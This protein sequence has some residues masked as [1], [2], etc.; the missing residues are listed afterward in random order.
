MVCGGVR[1]TAGIIFGFLLDMYGPAV[2]NGVAGA[3]FVA[4]CIVFGYKISLVFGYG[5]I[6]LAGA[7]TPSVRYGCVER[8]T[9]AVDRDAVALPCH[10]HR[11]SC[12]RV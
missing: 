6:A 3:L 4:G 7:G 10:P 1:C 2:T 11:H 9:P 5:M 12:T 8:A